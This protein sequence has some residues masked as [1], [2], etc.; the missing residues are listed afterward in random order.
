MTLLTEQEARERWCPFARQVHALDPTGVG[1]V[2]RAPGGE[3]GEPAEFCLC[4]AGDCMAWRWETTREHA[5]TPMQ[6][7]SGNAYQAVPPEGEGWRE[8]YGLAINPSHYRWE[9]FVRTGLGYCGLASKPE[10]AG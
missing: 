8:A 7:V 10:D 4:I 2:N 3:G 6:N 1:S 9:R 5:T